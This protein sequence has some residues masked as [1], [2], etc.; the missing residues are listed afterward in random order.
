MRLESYKQYTGIMD[1]MSSS[2]KMGYYY[3]SS[4]GDLHREHELEIQHLKS[5]HEQE[6]AA[7]K[8]AF[9]HTR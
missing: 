7:L 6:M 5:L 3:R 4:V 9:S 8:A 1:F 2:C